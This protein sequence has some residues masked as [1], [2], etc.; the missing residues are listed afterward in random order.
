MHWQALYLG[1]CPL[2]LPPLLALSRL[3]PAPKIA[4]TLGTLSRYLVPTLGNCS[5]L[6]F[7]VC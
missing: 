7:A 2:T 6:Q 1:G 3:A 5:I 4:L